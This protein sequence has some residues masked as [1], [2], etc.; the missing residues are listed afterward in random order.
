MWGLAVLIAVSAGGA[1]TAAAFP[2]DPVDPD[3]PGANCNPASGECQYASLSPIELR[4][5]NAAAAAGQAV[6]TTPL[7]ANLGDYLWFD[8]WRLIDGPVTV[9][10]APHGN[11]I[12]SIDAGFNFVSVLSWEGNDW[13]QINYGQW[14]SAAHLKRSEVSSFS[15]LLIPEPPDRPFGWMLLDTHPSYAPGGARDLETYVLRYT[16]ITVYASAEVDGWNWY[17]IGPDQWVEQRR[18]ALVHPVPRPEGVSGRWVAVD[19]YE[20]IAIAYEDDEMVFV[21][22]VST[23]LPQWPTWEGLFQ[24]W[25]RVENGKMSGAEGQ[26]DFYYLENVPWTMYFDDD[27]SLHGT[28]WHDGFGY[29]H[30]HGCVNL[31]ITDAAWFYEWTDVGTWVYVYSSGEYV[32]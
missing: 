26:A 21:T 12:G 27:I 18:V 24:V 23:G 22:L 30:S 8:Y 25:E 11:P 14:V 5:A 15:G 10:D 6:R 7:E 3:A 16:P 29:R 32:K 20:Q 4:A 13:A 31:S 1:G 19:L 28:Y 9:Y 17:L 2:A